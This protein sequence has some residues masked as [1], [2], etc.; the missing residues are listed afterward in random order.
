MLPKLGILAGGGTL[1]ALLVDTCIRQRRPFFVI[2]F[3]GQADAALVAPRSDGQAVPH[4]WVR[5]GAAGRAIRLLRREGA[6][7]LVMTG[8]MRRPSLMSLWPDLWA[9]RFLLRHRGLKRGDDALL[10]ALIEALADEDFTV[11]GVD[12]LLP[13]LLAPKGVLGTAQPDAAALADVKLGIEAALSIGARDVG[14]AAVARQGRV[15]GR[16][17]REGTDAMLAACAGER[18]AMPSGVLVKMAKPRQERRVD[19]PTIGPGTI[20][21]AVRAG[22]AGIA[23]EAGSALL[24]ERDAMI[25]AA[26]A[27]GLFVIGV[28]AAEGRS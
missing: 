4:A 23:V 2:A 16:E 3:E 8:R 28:D 9:L 25:G 20:A 14:Q 24:V 22:L 13:E 12:A 17:G 18:P 27:A 1:P 6:V 19:L 11:V 15:I 21:A 10:R 26:D 7:E 5:V